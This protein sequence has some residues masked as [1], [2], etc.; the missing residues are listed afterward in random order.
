M[1]VGL[2]G[3][4]FNDKSTDEVVMYIDYL[5]RELQEGQLN[6]DYADITYSIYDEVESW[7]RKQVSNA[8]VIFEKFRVLNDAANYKDDA[9]KQEVMDWIERTRDELG[10]IDNRF[11]SLISGENVEYRFIDHLGNIVGR[12][13]IKEDIL[14]TPKVSRS[15]KR[16]NNGH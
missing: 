7:T 3:E 6:P 11:N 14:K 2:T 8:G 10:S 9:M 5:W 13:E 4:D 16:I 12:L 1:A 15:L